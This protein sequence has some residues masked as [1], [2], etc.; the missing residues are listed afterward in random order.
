MLLFKCTCGKA[1]CAQEAEA[2]K[3]VICTHCGEEIPVPSVSDTDCLLIFRRGDPDNGQAM[4]STEFQHLLN[5]GELY[6]YDLL[7]KDGEW[8][9]LGKVYELPA[10]PAVEMDRTITEIALDFQDL[11]PVE[12]FAKVPRKK[13]RTPKFDVAEITPSQTGAAAPRP[14]LN[15]KKKISDTIKTIIVVSILLFGGLRLGRIINFV[16]KRV[17]NVMVVNTF[18]APCKFKLSGYEWQELPK[19]TYITQPDVYVAFSCKKKML[20]ME[21]VLDPLTG[22]PDKT[23]EGTPDVPLEP[24]SMRVPIKPGA[25]TVVNPGGRAVF[26]VYDFSNLASLSLSSPELKSLSTELA[27]A[28]PPV[29]ALKVIQQIQE[30][31][32]DTYKESRQDVFFTSKDYDF[33]SLGIVRNQDF[34]A[35]Q[36]ETKEVEKPP[37]SLVY[38]AA[39]TLNFRNG[40]VLFDPNN[41]ETERSI[42]LVSREFKPKPGYSVTGGAPRLQIRYEKSFLVLQLSGLQGDVK[43]PQNAAY[44]AQWTYVARMDKAGKWTWL[45]TAKYQKTGAGKKAPEEKTLTID[46]AGKETYPKGK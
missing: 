1:C 3:K 38:P 15:L 19:N 35:P 7:K 30:L 46:Q 20:F 45:W 40:S 14:P 11:P 28:K 5:R 39:R 6:S 23:K 4:T 13:K 21:S 34:S 42:A 16:L 2:G 12:G 9:P 43:G 26:G 29:S 36:D 17:S 22:L 31:V 8:V 27:Q 37:L 33:D 41:V 25:D 24:P 32:K 18:D 10:P 44:K